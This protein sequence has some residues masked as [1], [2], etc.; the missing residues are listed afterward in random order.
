MK[1]ITLGKADTEAYEE[2]NAHTRASVAERV[3]A[4]GG[5]AHVYG[6]AR[7]GHLV[8]LD[9]IGAPELPIMIYG[10]T[11]VLRSPGATTT[12]THVDERRAA[13]YYAREYLRLHGWTVR[14]LGSGEA[15]LPLKHP[16]EPMMRPVCASRPRGDGFHAE[17]DERGRR[18]RL[19][20]DTSGELRPLLVLH[21]DMGERPMQAGDQPTIA[22]A[23]LPLDKLSPIEID[24]PRESFELQIG[25]VALRDLLESLKQGAA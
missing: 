5:A 12:S 20:L 11:T 7:S 15:R 13:V 8:L 21:H 19:T 22:A 9:S 2:R 25:G 6:T 3:K 16:D 23:L 4:L 18:V 14:P 1:M 17:R 10:R 24:C